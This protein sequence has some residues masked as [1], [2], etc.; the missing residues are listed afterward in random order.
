M[1]RLTKATHATLG[2]LS[3][4]LNPQQVRRRHRHLKRLQPTRRQPYSSV[5]LTL[6]GVW[7]KTPP[8][9]SDSMLPSC[10]SRHS[11]KHLYGGELH[12]QGRTQHLLLSHG[13]QLVN[14]GTQLLTRNRHRVVFKIVKPH[15]RRLRS[16]HLL[17]CMFTL[18]RCLCVRDFSCSYDLTW[19]ERWQKRSESFRG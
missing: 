12:S 14:V 10:S 18:F 6:N 13:N 15:I 17:S 11:L 8:T 19:D 9:P 3:Q 16:R 2:S 4:L 5:L 7:I 1:S